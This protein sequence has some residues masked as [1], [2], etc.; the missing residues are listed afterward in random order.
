MN[1]LSKYLKRVVKVVA[2]PSSYPTGG[3]AVSIGELEKVKDAIVQ[4]LGAGEYLAQRASVSGNVVT[5]VVRNNIE[6]AVNEGGTATYTI[7]AEIAA[8]SNISGVSFLIEA[9]GY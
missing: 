8:G 4:V 9:F 7:G 2:G 3:F 6:Q 1:P 5:I